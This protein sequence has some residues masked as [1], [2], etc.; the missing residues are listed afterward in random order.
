MKSSYEG[1]LHLRLR[2]RCLII[3]AFVLFLMLMISKVSFAAGDDSQVGADEGSTRT[4][5]MYICGSDLESEGGM[6][7][8]NIKQILGA[9][10]CQDENVKYIIM[11]GGALRWH[12][13]DDDDSDNDNGYLVFPKEVPVQEDAVNLNDPDDPTACGNPYSQISNVYNQVWEARGH[14]AA[15]DFGKMVLLDGDGITDDKPVKSEDE[16]MSNPETLKAFINYGIK[17]YPA[18]KYDLILW[19]HAGGPVSGFAVDDHNTGS[20]DT[21]MRFSG[22]VDALAHNDLTDPEDG[23]NARKF[24]FIDFDAC[25]MSC[26]ELEFA[27]A[28]Y[29][30]CY[31]ASAETEP[32]YGQEYSGW[33]NLVGSSPNIDAYSIGKKAVDSFYE[34]Y[35]SGDGKG[36]QG[37]LAVVDL[38]KLMESNFIDSLSDMS[39]LL[40]EQN[41]QGLFYDEL[42]SAND[43]LRYG[44]S[45]NY[46]DLGN[47][48]SLLSVVKLEI[49]MDELDKDTIKTDNSYADS[50]ITERICGILQDQN[51]VYARGNDG[52]KSIDKIYRSADGELV[53][54]DLFT[55]GLYIFFTTPDIMDKSGYLFCYYEELCKVMEMLPDKDDGRY[56]FLKGYIDVLADY[57][58]TGAA[59]KA[60]NWLV[61]DDNI[62]RNDID[63]ARVRDYWTEG[64]ESKESSLWNWNIKYLFDMRLDGESEEAKACLDLIIKQ[65]AQEAISIENVTARKTKTKDGTGYKV[66]IGDTRNRAISNVDRDMTMEFS[67]LERYLVDNFESETQEMIRHSIGFSSGTVHGHINTD[68]V[69]E[70]ASAQEI[71]RWNNKNESEWDIDAPDDRWYAVKDN[72]GNL[73][74]AAIYQETPDSY[75]VAGLITVGDENV[76]VIL[77]FKKGGDGVSHDDDVASLTEIMFN[78]SEGF[79]PIKVSELTESYAISLSQMV[80]IMEIWEKPTVFLPTSES[81][82]KLAADNAEDITLQYTDIKKISDIKDTDGDGEVY[83]SLF[84]IK[85]IYSEYLNISSIVNNTEEKLIG[86][87]LARVRPGIYTGQ[88]LSPELVYHDEIL[89]EGK[90]YT[91]EFYGLPEGQPEPDMTSVGNYRLQFKGQGRFTGLAVRQFSIILSENVASEMVYA[92]QE[93]VRKATEALEIAVNDPNHTG[94]EDAYEALIRA[95][96]T[97]ADAEEALSNTQYYLELDEKEEYKDKLSAL[98]DQVQDLNAELAKAKVIDI[99]N[100]AVTMDTSFTYTG[101]PIEPEIT[102]SGLDES[103]YRITY[104]DNLW[105][106]TAYVTIE[107]RAGYTGKITKNYTIN[108]QKAGIAKIEA[109]ENKMVI[110]AKTE[111]D[112][113]GGS[114]YQIRYKVKGTSNWEQT[115]AEEQT[116]TI[117]NLKAGN[118]YQV[119]IRAC[120]T[121]NEE[122]YQGEWS[123]EKIS[124]KIKGESDGQQGSGS[125]D[126]TSVTPSSGTATKKNTM[127]VKAKKT[128]AIVKASK[129]KK[130]KKTV[131][132][133]KLMTVRKAKGNVTY[134]KVSVNK[135]SKKFTVKAGSGKVIIKKGV[136][137][138]T[139]KIRIKVTATGDSDYKPASKTVTCI[140]KVN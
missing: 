56:A 26:V 67:A 47:L 76:P 85:D 128:P 110:T 3:T 63:Y 97:L 49:T 21:M 10:F 105:V 22:I 117:N 18:D 127:T 101:T 86:I 71:I 124:D 52:I 111:A 43:S 102:I 98:E 58:L 95:Q 28:D 35:D 136:K 40:K 135:N 6:A 14:N 125:S 112:V 38:K 132:R 89:E 126:N 24:D 61:N 100:Y 37:T 80:T 113:T 93:D 114:Y 94:I 23:S 72:E 17:N 1:K 88:K 84:T 81:T 134:K 92:A 83:H 44:N 51:I 66:V 120:H 138:G 12:L 7:T 33:L 57:A 8:F 133:D 62:D 103:A 75:Y 99:S 27:L 65:Q 15:T 109:G 50:A 131:S 118:Q 91:W 29:T 123:E 74:A 36:Q 70:G 41:M 4:I 13:D 34:F 30:D 20:S 25:L 31:I 130:G 45:M 69:S 78:S 32:G 137:K 39:R 42:S 53:M 106:G 16:L 59:G 121:V 116:G 79:R 64:D 107:G 54:G 140:I 122:T 48:A 60:V 87:D 139:Y 129:L 108:P 73:H 46:F 19:D 55:S 5:L 68:D 2:G 96:N 77:V 9:D 119:Q 104:N 82:L 11:T 115:T 90:D